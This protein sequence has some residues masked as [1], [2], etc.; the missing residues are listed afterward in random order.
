MIINVKVFYNL[1]ALWKKNSD[2]NHNAF[3]ALLSL[4]KRSYR[5][6]VHAISFRTTFE[7]IRNVFLELFV[8]ACVVPITDM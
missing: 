4:S 5:L 7:I 2:L 3:D 8:N 1:F 6:I